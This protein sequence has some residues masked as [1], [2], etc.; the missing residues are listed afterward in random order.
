V[1]PFYLTSGGDTVA[2]IYQPVTG[3][4]TGTAVLIVP[5]FGWDDQTSY[6]P[7]R[8]WSQALAA[9][10]FANLRIDLPGTGDSSGSARD[11]ALV[12]AWTAAV[13]AGVEWLRNAGADRIAVIA[14]GAGGLLTLR[15]IAEGS[16]VDDL[17]LWGVPATGRALIREIKAFGRL[18]QFQTG[19]PAEEVPAD[20]LCAG[21]HVLGAET[22]A[23]L[24]KLDGAGLSRRKG[25]SR[26]LI[27]GRDGIGPDQGLLEALEATG[28]DVRTNPGRGWGA[29]LERAQSKSPTA[30]FAAVNAW[31]AESARPGDAP[32]GDIVLSAA[33]FGASGERIRET[34]VVFNGAGRQLFAVVAEPID[35]P[36]ADGTVVLFNAGAIRRIGPNRMWT[37]ASRRWAAMG[38]P[39]VRIDLEGIGDAE[40][41]SSQYTTDEGFYTEAL[42]EQARTALRLADQWRLP[43]RFLLAGLCSGAWWSFELALDD[44]RVRGVIMLNP[45]LLAP[46]TAAEG[47]RELRKL[48]RILTRSGFRNMLQEKHKLRRA[49][50]F[51][52]FVAR[53]PQRML[54]EF[55]RS[56]DRPLSEKLR[57]LQARGQRI[58]MAFSGDEPLHDELRGLHGLAALENLGVR[59]HEL[60]YKSHTLKPMKA[61]RAAHA[62]L[63]AIVRE[64]FRCSPHH[65]IVEPAEPVAALMPR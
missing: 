44:P 15:A 32:V 48:G 23:A 14:L 7:R 12:E 16:A 20:E 2:A 21:G 34:P 49:S 57:T 30:I 60:P 47:N 61:Q 42:V 3:A 33:E 53:T 46:D 11:P 59:F 13:S 56:A 62:L 5:P 31:L 45:R 65:P 54:R 18:E 51:A 10:G 63:D 27:L 58:D 35:A 9:K 8:D 36:M 6:R 22:I 28:A 1:K 39:V 19:E 26:A 50:R 38:V 43:P 64:S 29:A 24:S 4:A 55:S 17:V 37:E 25:P 52:S 41:D 40:G